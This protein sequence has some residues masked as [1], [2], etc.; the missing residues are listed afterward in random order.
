MICTDVVIKFFAAGSKMNFFSQVIR[1]RKIQAPN[2][3]CLLSDEIVG[4]IKWR[5][6]K[7]IPKICDMFQRIVQKCICICNR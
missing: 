6:N 5:G 4:Y 1:L 7:F 2:L 3:S